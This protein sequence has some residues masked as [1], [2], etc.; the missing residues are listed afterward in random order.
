MPVTERIV[1][2]DI[3]VLDKSG[4]LIAPPIFGTYKIDR[5]RERAAK[6]A[7]KEA[8]QFLDQKGKC[9]APPALACVPP[10]KIDASK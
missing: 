10:E 9:P 5:D 8:L 7:F 1:I 2:L 3:Y 6:K 4:C